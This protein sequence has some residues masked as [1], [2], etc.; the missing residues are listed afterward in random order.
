MVDPVVGREQSLALLREHLPVLR[1]RFGVCELTLFG[2]TARDEATAD[3]DVD[4]LV[5]FDHTPQ[6]SWGCYEAQSYLAEALRPQRRSWSS[7]A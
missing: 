2:S 7:A 3:S 1:E 6:T 4:I 5:T